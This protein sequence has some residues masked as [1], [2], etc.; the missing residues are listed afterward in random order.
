M[1]YKNH[2]ENIWQGLQGKNVLYKYQQLLDSNTGK[3]THSRKKI[4]YLR[5]LQKDCKKISN[6]NLLTSIFLMMTL[7]PLVYK[8]FFPFGSP[9]STRGCPLCVLG[10]AANIYSVIYN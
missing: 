8:K 4:K 5:N 7:L 9:P 10:N 1:L 2:L 3:D 6:R